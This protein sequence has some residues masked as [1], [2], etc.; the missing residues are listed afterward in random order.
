MAGKN[1]RCLRFFRFLG[2][3]GFNVRIVARG[4][5]DTE[6]RLKRRPIHEEKL[7]HCYVECYEIIA[8]PTNS[9][10][11]TEFHIKM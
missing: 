10:K 7:M 9:N 5:L 11:F 4:T 3:L 8:T 1:L 6:I 2:F